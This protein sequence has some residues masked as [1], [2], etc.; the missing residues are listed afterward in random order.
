MKVDV[1][2]ET[3]D[4]LKEFQA[5]AE[6]WNSRINLVSGSTLPAFW[7]RHISDSLQIFENAAPFSGHWADLGSG[8]GF[9]GIVLAVA[10]RET[11]LSF[12][13]VESDQRKATFLRTAIRELSLTNAKVKCDRIERIPS[14]N[15]DY[16]SARALAGLP[17]LLTFLDLHLRASGEAWLLKGRNWQAEVD[18]ARE[19]WAFNLE[20]FP[21]KTSDEAA[22]LKVSEVSH[23]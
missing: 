22:V 9:P 4:L 14:L 19:N 17:V 2:R 1:S 10:F 16:V 15:A 18:E 12:T 11:D 7:D 13:L 3:M 5:L 23:V 8:G 21:S 20:T 6:K